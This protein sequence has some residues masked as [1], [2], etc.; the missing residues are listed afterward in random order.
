MLGLITTYWPVIIFLIA[1][2]Y[3]DISIYIYNHII[4]IT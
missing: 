3:R 4:I 1:I 2:P